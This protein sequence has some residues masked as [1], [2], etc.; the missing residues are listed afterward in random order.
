MASWK[1]FALD[2]MTCARF[3][4]W[5]SAIG[6]QVD[7]RIEAKP[8][9]IRATVPWESALVS[10]GFYSPHSLKRSGVHR[11]RK[12]AILKEKLGPLPKRHYR[13]PPA[14]QIVLLHYFSSHV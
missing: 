1:K 2:S 5:R 6:S 8:H 10:V 13:L 7:F 4:G 11:G 14:E 12:N 9:R 3:R